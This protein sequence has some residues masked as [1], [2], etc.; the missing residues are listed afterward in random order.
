[1]VRRVSRYLIIALPT[2]IA[3]LRLLMSSA[4]T[5][6]SVEIMSFSVDAESSA[7]IASA[8]A[9]PTSTS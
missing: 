3:S 2:E 8:L 7:V 4:A 6:S 9:P 1:M 5:L